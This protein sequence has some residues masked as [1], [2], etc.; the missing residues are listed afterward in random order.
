MV[1]LRH[2]WHQCSPHG[3]VHGFDI[4]GKT[5]GVHQRRV[6]HALTKSGAKFGQARPIGG[7]IGGDPH[8]LFG[9]MGN[10]VSEAR[11]VSW[12]SPARPT[13]VFPTRVMTGTP[14][15]NESRLVVCPL[16]GNVSRAMSMR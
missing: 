10:P 9:C 15:Q 5:A 11:L 2:D 3:S 4:A 7:Q 12:P 13:T 1:I 16:Y 8:K 6:F 14:I